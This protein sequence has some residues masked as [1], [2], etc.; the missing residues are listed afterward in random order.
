MTAAKLSEGG[1][2]RQL[3]VILLGLLLAS[4]SDYDSQLRRLETFVSWNRIGSAGDV[5]IIK[6][7]AF[8]QNEKVGLIFGFMDGHQFCRE[9]AEMYMRRFPR[10]SYPAPL[11]IE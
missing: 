2:M 3:F 6:L 5:W 4:C 8:G 9:I 11:P 1:I 7:N 10:A